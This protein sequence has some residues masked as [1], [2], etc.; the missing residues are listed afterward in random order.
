MFTIPRKSL[1]SRMQEV[2]TLLSYIQA[3]ESR[4][5]PPLDSNEVKII[6]GLFFVHLYGAFE[7]S[8]NEG[9][10]IYLQKINTLRVS[11]AHAAPGFLPTILAPEFTSLGNANAWNG[12]VRLIK[13]MESVEIVKV[14]NT[15]FEMLMQNARPK[16]LTEIAQY[17]GISDS[18]SPDTRDLLY[19]DEVVEKR[20]QVAHGRASPL[21]V[22]GSGRSNDLRDRYDA[23]NRVLNSFLDLLEKNFDGLFFLKEDERQ[24]YITFV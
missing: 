14:N 4:E 10:E 3:A 1:A 22:G 21:R 24:Q 11:V 19:L 8:V 15:I 6:R 9:L 13:K 17:L 16:R 7:K 20:N 18:I 5:T 12:R 2:R 23:V